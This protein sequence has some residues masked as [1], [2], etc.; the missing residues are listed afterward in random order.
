MDVVDEDREWTNP[1]DG[2]T[3]EVELSATAK[4]T[5][6]VGI[7]FRDEDGNEW[8]TTYGGDR[9]GGFPPVDELPRLLRKAKGE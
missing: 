1:E 7:L 4:E 5:A 2:K 6:F 9:A 8:R 3:Y